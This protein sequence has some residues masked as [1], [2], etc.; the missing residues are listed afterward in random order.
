[1]AKED[2]KEQTALHWQE[3]TLRREVKEEIGV[4][5]L[6]I[7]RHLGMCLTD[8]RIRLHDQD[9]GLIVSVFECSI[10]PQAPLVISDEHT[11]LDWSMPPEA[12]RRLAAAKFSSELCA[13]VM[14]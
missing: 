13:L 8:I 2:S 12:A 4:E 5:D 1:M 10:P 11:L 3:Q 7:G 9:V 6:R 14:G